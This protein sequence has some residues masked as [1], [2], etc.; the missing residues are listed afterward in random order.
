MY[1]KSYVLY[2]FKGKKQF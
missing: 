1:H 2:L